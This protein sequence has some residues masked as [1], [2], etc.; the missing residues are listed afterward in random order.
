MLS[1]AIARD[2][3]LQ[4]VNILRVL[5]MTSRLHSMGPMGNIKHD[6]LYFE[7]VRQVVVRTS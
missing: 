2:A 7:E 6:V 3:E 5:W 1:V 4:Y